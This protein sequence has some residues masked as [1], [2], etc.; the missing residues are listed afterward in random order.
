MSLAELTYDGLVKQVRFLAESSCWCSNMP[1]SPIELPSVE[2]LICLNDQFYVITQ[3]PSLELVFVSDNIADILGVKPQ[4]FTIRKLFGLIHPEDA[5]VVLLASKKMTELVGS[6]YNEIAPYDSVFTMDFRLRKNDGTFLRFLNQNSI[7]CKKDCCFKYLSLSLYTDI[8]HIKTSKKIEFD[9]KHQGT[10]AIIEFPDKEIHNIANCF[11]HREL[12]ILSLLAVGKNSAEIGAI[13][14]IS[15]HTV[16]T[17][18]RKML[19]KSHLCNTAELV[20]YSIE[21]EL[22]GM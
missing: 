13:L 9:Y 10:G 18:R 3:F 2:K 1:D 14:H 11:T 21:N 16:D 7:I 6:R 15:R 20:A 19:A 8:T 22:I 4:G 5:P 12:E 17:H